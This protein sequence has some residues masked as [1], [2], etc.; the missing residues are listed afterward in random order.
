MKLEDLLTRPEG[1]TLEFKRNL[2]SPKNILKTLTAFA[3]TAGGILLIGIEDKSKAVI[4][5][6][7]PLDEEERLCSLIMDSIEPRLVPNIEIINWKGRILI[8]VEVYPSPQRPHWLK[9]IGREDGVLVRVGS[10]NRLADGPLTEELRRNALNIC[11]DE[12][13]L[14]QI[15]P[16]TL[17]VSLLSGLKNINKNKMLT[18]KLLTH[19]QGRV[20]PTVGGVLLFGKTR[21][22]HFPDAWVQ[23]GRFDG[24]NK[25]SILD[26]TDVRDNLPLALEKAFDFIKKHASRRAEFGELKRK[27]IWNMPLEAVREGLTNAIVHADYSQIGA[28]IRIA[29]FDDRIEIENPGLLLGGL[30]IESLRSGVSKLRNRVIGRIFK[31]LNLIEEW[32]SGF[33]RMYDNCAQGHFPAPIFEE[34]AHHFRVTFLLT[35]THQVDLDQTDQKILKYIE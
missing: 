7:K 13:P 20:V 5:I 24:V 3:N 32:G 28:P 18:L 35:C 34:V 4:G 29:I 15:K 11:Y 30:T 10:T 26:Q 17:D 33:Q 14:P 21:E 19:Y 6:E 23:C 8:G 22:M 9:S 1:K 12:E 31:E 27:D 25:S 16:D 2:S